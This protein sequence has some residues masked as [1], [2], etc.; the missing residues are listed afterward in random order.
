MMVRTRR[1]GTKRTGRSL[2]V[3][4][5]TLALLATACGGGRGG[6]EDGVGAPEPGD[7]ADGTEQAAACPEPDA[8]ITDDAVK[9]GGIYPLSGPA[10]AYGTIP[11]GLQ[12]YFD[13]VNEEQGGAPGVFEGREIEF[14]VKDDAYSPPRSVEVVRE[15]VEQEQVF[16]LVQTLGTP[17]TTAIWDYTNEQEVPQVFVAT[18][19]SKFGLDAENH[20]WT[21]GWQPNYVSESRVYAQY[22]QDN[23]PD[24]TV[25]VLFQNDDYGRDYLDGFKEAIAD[26]GIEIVAEESYQTTDPTV[27]SQMT[28]LAQSNA[29]VFFN[30]TTPTFAA[31]A[32]AFDAQ[33][34]WDPVHLLNSVSN[35]LAIIGQ[36]GFENVQGVISAAYLKDAVDPQWEGDEDM[37]RFLEK[38]ATYAPDA[39]PENA[40]NAYGWAV[41]DSFYKVMERTECPTRESLMEAVRNLDDVE[42]DLALPGVTMTTSGEEDG[43]PLE[44][45]QIVV[46]EGESFELQGDVIQTREVFGP[47]GD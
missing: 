27:E 10:S 39:D 34:D 30:I 23:H 40:F 28:N 18:G 43:F 1:D 46:F 4:L 29:D 42:F 20:P 15:L 21:V 16:A 11:K 25:A 7:G 19:A 41:A 38:L 17:P 6:D 47:V 24:A 32:L 2:A 26:S 45:M 33:S 13:Y 44:A 9:I 5:A 8:G 31:Q 14:T 22:L 37:Q 3:W 35:S 12:A 36:V